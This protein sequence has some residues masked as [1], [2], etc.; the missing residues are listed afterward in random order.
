[1]EYLTDLEARKKIVKAYELDKIF[2]RKKW[3]RAAGYLINHHGIRIDPK[4]LKNAYAKLAKDIP[5]ELSSD[6]EPE[7]IQSPFK[8]PF[9][10][11]IPTDA[12]ETLIITRQ[13]ARC[14][15]SMA[16]SLT[17][18]SKSLKDLTDNVTLSKKASLESILA[19]ESSED[20][21]QQQGNSTSLFIYIVFV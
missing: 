4:D 12:S 9:L 11:Q 1:M 16:E 19:E 6:E 17:I 3:G 7:G 18:I 2:P 13:L 10:P 21:C 5:I 20:D 14:A 15:A 8:K